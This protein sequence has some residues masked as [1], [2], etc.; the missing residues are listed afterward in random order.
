M[1]SIINAL[2]KEGK[3]SPAPAPDPAPQLFSARATLR[4]REVRGKPPPPP[5]GNADKFA[6]CVF[7][8]SAALGIFVPFIRPPCI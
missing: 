7:V 5:D 4:S 3:P 2:K 6:A 1:K 8:S